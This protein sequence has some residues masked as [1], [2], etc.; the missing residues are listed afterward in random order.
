MGAAPAREAES[1]VWRR[2]S[3]RKK[4]SSPMSEEP[5]GSAVGDTTND[6][7]APVAAYVAVWFITRMVQEHP[8]QLG[9]ALAVYVRPE[10][11]PVYGWEDNPLAD[12]GGSGL[13]LGDFA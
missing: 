2:K 13:I 3:F 8:P 4:N 6:S 1:I 5:R 11:A 9:I 10:I 7:I 12:Y